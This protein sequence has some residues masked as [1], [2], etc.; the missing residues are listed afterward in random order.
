MA[1]WVYC[2]G[3]L[4][5]AQAAAEINHQAVGRSQTV[6]ARDISLLQSDQYDSRSHPAFYPVRSSISFPR[7]QDNRGVKLLPALEMRR[8][9]LPL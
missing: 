9:L 1:L 6:L 5:N 4:R 2:S 3:N 8:V 7:G